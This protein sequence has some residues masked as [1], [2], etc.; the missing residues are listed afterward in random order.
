MKE[1]EIEAKIENLDKVLGF[2]DEQLEE[3]ECPMKIQLQIDVAG[4]RPGYLHQILCQILK[5]L[6][7]LLQYIKI[8][9]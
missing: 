8:P 7:F 9:F 5:P 3:M 4:A 1:L 2:V 6:G